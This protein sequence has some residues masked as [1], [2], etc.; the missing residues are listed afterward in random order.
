MATPENPFS[1]D[2]KCIQVD[3]PI[4]CKIEQK[5]GQSTSNMEELDHEFDNIIKAKMNKAT[6]SVLKDCIPNGLIK[7][8]PKNNISAMVETGAKGGKVN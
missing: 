3:D 7:R 2:K 8:F 6:S 4:R 5:I 1:T